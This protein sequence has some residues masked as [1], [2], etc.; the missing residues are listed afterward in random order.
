MAKNPKNRHQL[1][2]GGQIL[3]YKQNTKLHSLKQMREREG[4]RD[5]D[6]ERE[7]ETDR[8]THT[9]T[10]THRDRDRQTQTHTHRVFFNFIL[11]I[12]Y[13]RNSVVVTV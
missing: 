8:Q 13:L 4:G 1:E 12:N 5:R 7:T 10:H 11:K 9:H 6:T 3:D 2:L